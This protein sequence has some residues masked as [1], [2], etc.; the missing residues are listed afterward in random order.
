MAMNPGYRKL[1]ADRAARY[2]ISGPQE[3]YLKRLLNEAFSKGL[4][5]Q[6]G[7]DSH[8]LSTTTRKAASFA[9]DRLIKA[10]NNNWKPL[11][12]NDEFWFWRGFQ[13]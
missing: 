7:L 1:L 3:T 10:K 5:V 12:E 6:H 2:H 9:I 4:T 13:E 8:H 11:I